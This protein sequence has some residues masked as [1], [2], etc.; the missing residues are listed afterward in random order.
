MD[1]YT[2]KYQYGLYSGTE[3]V[4]ANNGGDAISKMWYRLRRY[5][6]IS[7]AYKSAKIIDVEMGS[8]S[9]KD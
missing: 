6:T 5:M 4:Y 3:V 8:A 1:K 9:Q 7:M 2:I